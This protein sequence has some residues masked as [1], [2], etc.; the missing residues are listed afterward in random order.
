MAISLYGI[1]TCDKVRLAEAWLKKNNLNYTFIDLKAT[2][3]EEFDVDLWLEKINWK[4]LINKKSK[5]WKSLSCEIKLSV[6]DDN[7]AKEVIKKNPLIMNRPLI[8]HDDFFFVG[9]SEEKY[10]KNLK[11]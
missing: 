3:M 8:K 7:N 5:T 6:V 9:F 4:L 1:K 10:E 2:V 11:K